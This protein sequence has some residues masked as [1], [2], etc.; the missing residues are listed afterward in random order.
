M[1]R[2]TVKKVSLIVFIVLLIQ[3]ILPASVSADTNLK[4]AASGT[5]SGTTTSATFGDVT[6]VTATV[7]AT[8]GDKI[9]VV[10]TFQIELTK[11]D[12]TGFLRLVDTANPT[13]LHS[14]TFERTLSG[15]AK[16]EDKGIGSIVHIFTATTTDPTFSLQH[17]TDAVKNLVTTGTIVAVPLVTTTGQAID[18]VLK[19]YF[20]TET[21]TSATFATVNGTDTSSGP[22]DP[23]TL[24]FAGHI[25]IAS[26]IESM[27]TTAGDAVGEWQLQYKLSGDTWTNL[28][29]PVERSM[30]TADEEGLVSLVGIV[31]E[32]EAGNYYFRLLHRSLTGSTGT[33][34]TEKANIVAVAL[35][36]PDGDYLDVVEA[37]VSGDTTISTSLEA[38]VSQTDYPPL[39]STNLF[40]HAQ[41]SLSAPGATGDVDYPF[42]DLYVYDEDSTASRLDNDGTDGSLDQGRY[43]S[44]NSDKGSGSS[45]ALSD[46]LTSGNH[47]TI[48]L[49]HATESGTTLTTDAYVVGFLLGYAT[50]Q[51]PIPEWPTLGLILI[52]LV[53]I[54][55][56]AWIHLRKREKK[57][58]LNNIN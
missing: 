34:Q 26:S 43:L 51:P 58:L 22:D 27:M 41:Y 44:D 4:A 20:G 3:L 42:F 18:N 38:A 10:A 6:G 8:S 5:G 35:A 23:L 19:E 13:N 49:R 53:G 30:H 56:Y 7:E 2:K 32:L 45:V 17:S 16:A 11:G 29:Y 31:R 12:Y 39:T 57:K 24:P 36:V 15:V 1:K 28:G 37:Y 50:G 52:G 40:L 48:S 47:H 14:E 9:L 54:A 55:G 46:S 21:T 25:Y 33:V